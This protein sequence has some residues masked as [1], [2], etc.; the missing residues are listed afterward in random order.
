[1]ASLRCS[2]LLMGIAVLSMLACFRFP[3]STA[4]RVCVSAQIEA[5]KQPTSISFY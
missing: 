5:N 1:M 3:T 2:D 4:A